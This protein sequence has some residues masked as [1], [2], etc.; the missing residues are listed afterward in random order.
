MTSTQ[1]TCTIDSP[2]GPLELVAVDG[3]L[4]EIHF[5]GT[6]PATQGDLDSDPVLREAV[7]QLTAYFGGVRTE[8]DLPLD[9][10]GSEFQKRV[11]QALTEVPYGETW[12]YAQLARHIGS[13]TA[14][15]AVGA[16]NGQN[17]LPVVVPCHRVVGTNGTL[18]G[19]GGGLDRKRVLLELEAK[20]RL[21]RDFGATL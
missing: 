15:R 11:W 1:H 19:Y 18:V 9:G 12:S 5:A 4:T 2:V 14:S 16:A 20:V 10:R 7:D 8:F 13:P 6:A 21:N 3:A 17:P